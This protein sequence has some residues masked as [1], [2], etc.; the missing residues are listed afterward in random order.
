MLYR[1][2]FGLLLLF[3]SALP[4]WATQPVWTNDTPAGQPPSQRF[5]Q[6]MADE[7]NGKLLMFGGRVGQNDVAETWEF[8][9]STGAWRQL[10][11]AHSPSA[12]EQFYMD[13]EGNGKILLFGGFADVPTGNS[14]LGDTWEWNGSDWT[15]V[16]T[17]GPSARNAGAMAR[18]GTGTMLL[19]GGNITNGGSLGFVFDTWLWS[20]G[21]WTNLNKST[22][23]H[24]NDGFSMCAEATTGKVL[25]FGGADDTGATGGGYDVNET[26]EW[27][28][29]AQAWSQK[30]PA[31][32]PPPRDGAGL[33]LDK[34]GYPV[35]FC[36]YENTASVYMDLNDTWEWTGSNWV[37]KSPAS[38]PSTRDSFG[39]AYDSQNQLTVLFSGI[40]EDVGGNLVDTWTWNGSNW[41]QVTY[42]AAAPNPATREGHALADEGGK[43]LLFGGYNGSYLNDTWEWNGTAWSQQSPGTSPS[44]RYYFAMADEGNGKILLFG[45]QN[46]SGLLGD[47][48]EWSGSSWSQKSPAHSPSARSGAAMAT[49]GSGT[50][51]LFGGDSTANQQ[52][53]TWEWS[54]SDWVQKSPAT[55]PTGRAFHEMASEGGGKV[56]MFGGEPASGGYL[57][58]TWEWSGTNWVNKNPS[59]S[60]SARALQ[61]MAYDTVRQRTVIFGGQTTAAYLNDVWEFNGTTWINLTPPSAP[62][63]RT[64]L[65]MAYDASLGAVGEVVL[66]G[67]DGSAITND[68]WDYAGTAPTFS[69]FALTN[70]SPA[71]SGASVGFTA[72]FSESVTGVDSTDFSLVTT[73]SVSGA[74]IT[75]VSTSGAVATVTVS[76]GTGGGTLA[77]KLTDDDTIRD[78]YGYPL[79]GPG[80]GTT[81]TSNAYTI[82]GKP[83]ASNGSAN[84]A[85][86]TATPLTLSATDTNS[87]AQT[88]TYAVATN[89]AHGTLS[90]FNAN[91]GVVTYTPATGY[92]GSDSFTFTATNSGGA[93][94]NAA[95]VTLTVAIGTPTADAQ[96]GVSVAHDT[97]KALALAAADDDSPAL[98][99]TYAIAT[100]PAHGTLSGFNAGT[101]AVTYTPSTGYHGTDS[102]TFTASNGTNTSTA[103]T[104]SLTV[105]VG[106]PTA[107][108]QSVT[109]AA[110]TA[111]GVTL[112]ATDNDTPALT[113][114]YTVAASPTHGL[115]SGTAPNLTYTPASNFAGTDS[116]TFTVS[117]GTNT[118]AAATVSITVTGFAP[119]ITSA[120][121]V[122]FTDGKANTFT[123]TTTGAPNAALSE[124]GTLPSGVTFTDNGNGTAT[125][126][127]M[128]AAGASGSF[129][130]MITAN[131]GITPNA[132]QSFSL[133]LNRPPVAGVAT[134]GATENTAVQV[135]VAKLLTYASDADGDTLSVTSVNGVS[136]QGGTVALSAPGNAGTITYTPASNF[137]GSDSFTYVVSDGRGGTTTGTVN[138]TVSSPNDHTL[139][140]VSITKTAAAVTVVYAGIPGDTYQP[141]YSDNLDG[142]PWINAGPAQTAGATNGLFTYVD[143]TQPQPAQRFYRAI[144]A[145]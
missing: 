49:D 11:P 28:N 112:S 29:T 88:L 20:N 100:N 138:V 61:G 19:Y 113:L 42:P 18:V 1:L 27:D 33:A 15:Q 16:A 12:R 82:V 37:Q 73:G 139:N 89:P 54:G 36:G 40:N 135:S 85:H 64:S 6:K 101:G 141:Q 58:D 132:T 131:N 142:G 124:S 106:T 56:L 145:Q 86:N 62:S 99:L 117:N 39:Y 109:T 110:N 111:K 79:G 10:S 75:N 96:S 123:I 31:T 9:T 22:H 87:P 72:T 95:T 25:L 98:T 92:H 63:V 78:L 143:T 129:P 107:T 93:T 38:K 133:V 126:S 83:N 84:V 57:G 17:T 65:G 7:G 50:V 35:L 68:T 21:S 91:T 104:V 8:T 122:V 144:A 32:L 120:A 24:V 2:L 114:T 45:G 94:S 53:D 69:A 137:T 59:T 67:G 26:W 23:P 52:A 115:L 105:A 43:I 130:L 108:A 97:A 80:T 51:L 127:G 118:S 128:P 47:T 41:S 13:Y 44:A 119:S 102:F 81:Y 76:S 134:L 90:N 14:R 4:V 46:G 70:G 60:P 3:S 71:T 34:N 121:S 77:L 30:S 5:G 66:F 55:I 116:F 136:A 125:L 48:W 140:V 74:S 103:A